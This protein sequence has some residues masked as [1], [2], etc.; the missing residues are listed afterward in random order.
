[1]PY[2]ILEVLMPIT[3]SSVPPSDP[4]A[5][6]EAAQTDLSAFIIRPVTT[7]FY[8]NIVQG[9][10]R[11]VQISQGQYANIVMEMRDPQGNV[12][13]LTPFSL[14]LSIPTEQVLVRFGEAV[15]ATTGVSGNAAITLEEETGEI[16]DAASGLVQFPIST[17]VSELPGVYI[18]EVGIFSA[19]GHMHFSNTIYIYVNKGLFTG[20]SSAAAV[21]NFGPPTLEE[22]RVAIRDNGPQ[23]NLLLDDLEF[24]IAEIGDCVKRA[25]MAWNEAQPP[26]NVFYT[27][28]NFPFKENLLRGTIGLLFRTAGMRSFRNEFQYSAGGLSI[29]DQSQ[30]KQYLPIGNEFWEE[31]RTWVRQKKAQFNAEAAM[32]SL[33]S[34]YGFYRKG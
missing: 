14:P 27:T 20:T 30:W 12:V 23:E 6:N 29:N 11:G 8:D 2:L 16:T 1:L 5:A 3:N 13:D 25:V 18:A 9:K 31:Y 4:G 33:G 26:I 7:R 24:D 22:I 34:A 28:R 15:Y 17:S 19:G 21:S 10:R 32:G